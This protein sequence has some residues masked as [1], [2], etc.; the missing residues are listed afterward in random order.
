[1]KRCRCGR[2]FSGC[3]LSPATAGATVLERAHDLILAGR[4]DGDSWRHRAWMPARSSPSASLGSPRI[5]RT[6]LWSLG[7][8][9]TTNTSLDVTALG[10]YD[11]AQTGGSQGLSGCSGCGEVGIYN[12]TGTLLVSALV[13][14][15]GTLIGDFY[16]VPVAAPCWR[17]D[18]P[19]TRSLKRAMP[20]IDGSQPASASTQTSPMSRTS[21]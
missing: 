12:S 1:M 11:A 10:F 19:I 16:Y 8:Q 4:R 6:E 7:F 20:I 14:T 9:F 17:R 13:T 2:R 18:R 15:S 5:S 3:W 21:S